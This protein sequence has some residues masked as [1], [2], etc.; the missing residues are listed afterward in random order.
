MHAD[1]ALNTLKNK[2]IF[3]KARFEKTISQ[4]CFTC[5][6]LGSRTVEKI[7]ER[8][9]EEE[10]DQGGKEIEFM[11]DNWGINVIKVSYIHA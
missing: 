6:V 3:L 7:E 8:T 10:Q 4:I 2:I 1:K 9:V 11:R 5:V